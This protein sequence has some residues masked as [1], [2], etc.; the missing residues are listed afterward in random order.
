MSTSVIAEFLYENSLKWTNVFLME[1]YLNL[2]NYLNIF[3]R[4]FC[5]ILLHCS[6][7]HFPRNKTKKIQNP[8]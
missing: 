4:N 2:I 5:E 3:K 6:T 1:K 7:L 8:V